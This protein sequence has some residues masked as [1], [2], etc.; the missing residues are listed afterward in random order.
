MK[1]TIYQADAFTDQV[2]GGNPAAVI[3][4]E[5][6]VED[7][8]MQKIALENNLSETAFLTPFEDGFQLRWFTPTAEVDLC[9]HATLA[10]AHILYEHLEYTG[11]VIKFF[12]KS[13]LLKVFKS[14]LGYCMDFPADSPQ[15]IKPPPSLIKGLQRLPQLVLKGTADFMVVFKNQQ[16]IENLT[17][18]F[19]ELLNLD[20]RGVITTAPGDTVDFVSRCFYPNVGIDE[21]PVTGSAHTLMTPY[22]ASRLNKQELSAIQLS[23]R[24]GYLQCSLKGDRVELKGNAVTYMKGKI[25]IRLTANG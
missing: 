9:G 17:P 8:L 10:S 18:D 25:K 5:E 23:N 21:D 14:D 12:T 19:K 1:F 15:E 3:P 7:D 2:F 22:W 13:G 20:T 4:L 6:W 11:E 24:K 16:E